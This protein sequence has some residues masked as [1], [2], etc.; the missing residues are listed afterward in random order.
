[1][2]IAVNALRHNLVYNADNDIEFINDFFCSLFCV[3]QNIA[4]GLV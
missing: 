2:N 1:M 3:C 4:F